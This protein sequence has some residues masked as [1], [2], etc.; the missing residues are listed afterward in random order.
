VLLEIFHAVIFYMRDNPK[1]KIRSWDDPYTREIGWI[2][3]DAT[4]W[5]ISLTQLQ[6]ERAADEKVKNAT[7]SLATSLGRK[8]VLDLLKRIAKRGHAVEDPYEA[9]TFSSDQLALL[10][11]IGEPPLPPPPPLPPAKNRFQIME[12]L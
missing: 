12:D 5:S 6:R 4:L 7:K 8:D 10:D 2:S 9:M 3:D 11:F 1:A